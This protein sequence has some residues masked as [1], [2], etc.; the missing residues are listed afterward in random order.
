MHLAPYN[1]VAVYDEE[2]V[3]SAVSI[4]LSVLGGTSAASVVFA[5]ALCRAAARGDALREEAL[6]NTP[7]EGDQDTRASQPPAVTAAVS[8]NATPA[9]VSQIPSYSAPQVPRMASRRALT[10]R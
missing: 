5:L 9:L 3:M 2:G 1:T 6:R 10:T 8:R 4:I 7:C